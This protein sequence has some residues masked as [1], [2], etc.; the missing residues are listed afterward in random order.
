MTLGD[1]TTAGLYQVADVAL[2][3]PLK[4]VWAHK[5]QMFLASQVLNKVDNGVAVC[6][7]TLNHALKDV[8]PYTISWALDAFQHMMDSNTWWIL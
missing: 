3:S 2:N 4:N 8:A 1:A 7:I 6:D 5:Y